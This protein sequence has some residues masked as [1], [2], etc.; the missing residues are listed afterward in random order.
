MVDPHRSTLIVA[1]LVVV[2][3][4]ILWAGA[5]TKPLMSHLLQEDEAER[6]FVEQLRRLPSAL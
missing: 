5:L 6:S 3:I 2:L 4:S 1:T